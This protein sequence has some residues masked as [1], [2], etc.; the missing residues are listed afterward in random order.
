MSI[1]V[2]DIRNEIRLSGAIE[3]YFIQKD[4]KAKRLFDGGDRFKK[5]DTYTSYNGYIDVR[6]SEDDFVRVNIQSEYRTKKDGNPTDQTL[7][8]EAMSEGELPSLR[9]TGNLL[10]TPLISFFGDYNGVPSMKFNDNYYAS[11]DGSAVQSIRIDLGFA[12]FSVKEPSK[13]GDYSNKREFKNEFVVHGY[14][15]KLD[16]EIVKDEETGRVKL[17]IEV[18]YTYG[19]EAKGNLVVRSMPLDLIG[20]MSVDDE[21]EFDVAELL[22]EEENTAGITELSW[23]I[24]GHIHGFIDT[25]QVQKSEESSGGRSLRRGRKSVD[26]SSSRGKYVQEFMIDYIAILGDDGDLFDRDDI[27]DAINARKADLENK[28]RKA[29][30]G[31]SSSASDSQAPRARIGRGASSS[32]SGEAKP[33]QRRG[34]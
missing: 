13:D 10:E 34:W 7:S 27:K 2:K 20:G 25:P 1:N 31:D 5:G 23:R 26:T 29:T 8:L 28:I 11:K 14:V 9:K 18:P 33:R 12:N 16:E 19:S 32:D 30:E 21:G 3:N 15:T 6:T 24:D 22:V 17:H 4:D